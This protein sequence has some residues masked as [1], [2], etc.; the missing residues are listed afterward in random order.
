MKFSSIA[1]PFCCAG[2]ALLSCV[3]VITAAA[4]AAQA[5]PSPR[6]VHVV[7]VPNLPNVQFTLDG[8]HAATDSQGT[9][10][11]PDSDLAGAAQSLTLPAQQLSPDLRVSLDRVANN[12]NHGPF[13]RNLVA[14]LDEQRAVSIHLLKPQGTGLA[15]S[16]VTSV[17]LNDSLGGTTKLGPS[18]LR[19]VVWL[20]SSRPTPVANGV[21]GV[22]RLVIYSVES[23]MIRG[24]NV[25]NSGQQTFATNRSLVWNVSV[26]LHSLTVQGNNLLAGAPAGSSV[27]LTYP[28]RTTQTFQ[29]ATNHRV[30]VLDLPR[31]TYQVKVNGGLVPLASTV[32]LS[33]DQTV[34][35][36]VVSTGDVLEMMAIALAVLVIIVGVGIIG[37]RRRRDAR[38]ARSEQSDAMRSETE[39]NEEAVDNVPV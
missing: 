15:L 22:G 36:L 24:T 26:I 28:N 14:E 29:F 32:H 30:T 10:T 5:A 6:T 33:R 9:A 13:T 19:S 35:D 27:Q 16:Q 4:P 3:V 23:V 37:R 38:R 7:V 21:A 18:Q 12:P 17:T 20:S 1:R 39:R 34:T 25:V 11:L 31:G 8:M 2:L